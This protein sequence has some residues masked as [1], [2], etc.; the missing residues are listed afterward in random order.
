MKQITAP[1]THPSSV[2]LA[3][4]YIQLILK[5]YQA[6]LQHYPD[7]IIQW[8]T[9][10]KSV[11]NSINTRIIRVYGYSPAQILFGFE[12]RHVSGVGSFEDTVQ[13][14]TIEKRIQEGL[15]DGMSIKEAA[16][17]S[18]LACLDE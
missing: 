10:L 13:S 17:E 9:F 8:D 1:I 7:I 18:R 15:E 12:P 16:Y 14:R 5:C 3:E 11:V 2:G 4:R 6:I